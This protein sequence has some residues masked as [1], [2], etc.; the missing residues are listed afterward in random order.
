MIEF[1]KT[2]REARE[3][4]GYSTSQVAEMTRVLPQIIESLEREDFSR[5][6]A[7]IYGRGFVKLYCE[8]VGIDPEPLVREFM[9]I[10]TGNRPPVIRLK[11]A[12]EPPIVTVDDAVSPKD[13]APAFVPPV[14]APAPE[15]MA[16]EPPRVAP[17]VPGP[18]DLPFP[19][20]TGPAVRR[21]YRYSGYSVSDVPRSF[22]RFGLLVV[23]ALAIIFLVV[24]GARA[25]Y[26]ATMTPPSEAPAIE[27]SADSAKAP[28]QPISVAPLYID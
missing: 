18:G 28:R 2:L 9:E 21:D 13:D 12:A 7:P 23:A 10:Y 15:P 4:R 5:I 1:G 14:E 17:F 3:A 25:L 19:E 6:V 20:E 8:C 26:R 16:S 24:L 11:D 27:T 22:W